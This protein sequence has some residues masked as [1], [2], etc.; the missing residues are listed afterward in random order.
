MSPPT[1]PLRPSP[2]VS[3]LPSIPQTNNPVQAVVE[4]KPPSPTE[5]SAPPASPSLLA[6]LSANLIK[7]NPSQ[8]YP[9][10]PPAS[11]ANTPT[12]P[13]DLSFCF[14]PVLA[15][16]APTAPLPERPQ[17]N[18]GRVEQDTRNYVG[19]CLYSV[20]VISGEGHNKMSIKGD[21]AM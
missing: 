16:Q 8:S 19:I 15:P 5:P 7:N 6:S 11:P 3:V 9:E 14:E 1:S 2:P 13:E 4:P 18:T 12:Q 10:A 20:V 21:G 17:P